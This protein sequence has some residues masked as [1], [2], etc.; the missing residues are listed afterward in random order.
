MKAVGKSRSGFTLIE[1]VVSLAILALLATMAAPMGEVVVQRN[2]EQEL[3]K[4]LRQIRDAID[5]Y[6]Q[7]YDDGRILKKVEATG[8]PPSLEVLEEGVPDSKSPQEKMIYFLRKLPRDP[9]ASPDLPAKDTWGLRSYAS[10]ASSPQKGDDVFDVYS[11][12]EKKGLNGV[13]YRDW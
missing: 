7:A 12:S 6:K 3:R 13:L 2:K 8:Y 5:A 4:S 10:S 1:L 9:F 11:L